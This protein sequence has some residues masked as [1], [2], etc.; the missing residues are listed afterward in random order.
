MFNQVRANNHLF[1][2]GEPKLHLIHITNPAAVSVSGTVYS[3]SRGKKF[4]VTSSHP[5]I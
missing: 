2:K 5:A 4:A 1:T 3:T